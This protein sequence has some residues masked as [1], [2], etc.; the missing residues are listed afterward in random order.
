MKNEMGTGGIGF[1]HFLSLYSY[2]T[3]QP[4][5]KCLSRR[6]R[7]MEIG[8]S[9]ERFSCIL[10][11]RMVPP[12]YPNW[13]QLSSHSLSVHVHDY[14]MNANHQPQCH[15]LRSIVWSSNANACPWT[16]PTSYKSSKGS[17]AFVTRQVGCVSDWV[18][19]GKYIYF[20]T[21]RARQGW[22]ARNKCIRLSTGWK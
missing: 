20:N 14:V 15:P 2:I 3:S 6:T 19:R 5:R 10:R 9:E 12:W 8:I 17:E 16:R 4:N 21:R 22:R 7:R 13:R 11:S 18:L 1:F